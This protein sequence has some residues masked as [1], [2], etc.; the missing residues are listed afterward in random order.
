[1]DTDI[2]T[3]EMDQ[4]IMKIGSGTSYDGISPDIISLIPEQLRT[5]IRKLFNG[6]FH[7]AYP[8]PWI[9]QLLL[10]TP[11]KGHTLS[12][13]KLRGVAMGPILSRL[14]DIIINNRF[15]TWYSPNSEQAGGR[16]KQ[17]CIIQIFAMLLLADLSR[18]TGVGLYVGLFDYEKAFDFVCRP[19]LLQ[20]MMKDG[21]GNKF[22]QCLYNMYKNT[23]Y[24]PQISNTQMG[25]EIFTDYGVTQG[26]SS[27]GS[28][29]S[30][31]ISDMIKSMKNPMITDTYLLFALLQLADDTTIF[32]ESRTSFKERAN[33]IALYSKH[34]HMRIN[35]PKT[36]YLNMGNSECGNRDDIIVTEDLCIKA[37]EEKEGYNWIGFWLTHTN[38]VHELIEFNLKKKAYNTAKFYEWLH[39]NNETPFQVKLDVLYSCLFSSLLYSCEAW[40]NLIKIEEQFNVIERKALK[41]ILGVKPSTSDLI[42][43]AEINRAEL[44]AIVM[45]R[46]EKFW[47]KFLTLSIEDAVAKSIYNFYREKCGHVENNFCQYYDNLKNN[48]KEANI[49]MINRKLHNSTS[50]L[51]LRYRLI[52]GIPE[53][54]IFLY[55]SMTNE[56]DRQLITRWR[57]SSHKLFVETGRRKKPQP[58]RDERLCIVCMVIEDEHHAIF[59]CTAHNFIRTDYEEHININNTVAKMLNPQ[60]HQEV[61]RVAEYLRKIEKN[62]EELQML[63]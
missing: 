48:N 25:E 27:S 46:Q 3:E 51:C 22:T 35:G 10:P 6:T 7:N 9:K 60:S 59:D 58:P 50:S 19:L 16:E 1:M 41:A 63:Q 28:L 34:K 39:I 38:K 23:S 47:D 29:F 13:P 18:I 20:N 52:I 42:V 57:L 11:K 2:S 54:P 40:G 5:S 31:F 15:L 12:D 53:N 30:F 26:R 24:V 4:A 14:F 45:D 32:G 36:K 37:V 49:E 62:M 56:L 17:G 21:A 44:S 33:R 43:Y 61:K 55:T 8:Q